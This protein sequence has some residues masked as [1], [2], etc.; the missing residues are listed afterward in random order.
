MTDHTPAR[1]TPAEVPDPVPAEWIVLDVREPFEWARGHL[2]DAVHI[3][4]GDL[5]ARVD[6][7]DPQRPVLVVCHLGQRSAHAAAWLNHVGREAINL[8]GGMDAWEAAGRT[9]VP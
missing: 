2:P 9:I 4:L 3:P 5:P 7:L 6:E 8:E 1:F